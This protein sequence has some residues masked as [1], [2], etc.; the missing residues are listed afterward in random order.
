M[1]LK[2]SF[3]SVETHGGVVVR[4]T[5]Q[6][7]GREEMSISKEPPSALPKIV[8]TA[9]DLTTWKMLTTLQRELGLETLAAALQAIVGYYWTRGPVGHPKLP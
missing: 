6:N 7:G 8:N 3:S 2:D 5:K 1:I 9:V 4:F